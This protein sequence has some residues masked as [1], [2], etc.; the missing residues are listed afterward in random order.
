MHIKKKKILLTN[1]RP[2]NDIFSIQELHSYAKRTLYYRAYKVKP[3]SFLARLYK[4]AE[5]KKYN[6]ARR[7]N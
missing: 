7:R 1:A 5:E 3:N 4:K 6:A 2:T